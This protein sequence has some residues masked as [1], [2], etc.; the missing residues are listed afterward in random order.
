MGIGYAV[1]P[2]HRMIF[3]DQASIPES[4]DARFA[5]PIPRGFRAT[6]WSEIEKHLYSP[7]IP[8]IVAWRAKLSE[9]YRSQLLEPLIWDENSAFE[10]SEDVATH[11]DVLLRYV[12]ALLDRQGAAEAAQLLFSRDDVPG[13]DI[14]RECAIAA[15]R[16]FAGA[17]PQLLLDTAFWFPFERDFIIEEPDWGGRVERFGSAGHLVQ[18]LEEIRN[19]IRHAE[20]SATAWAPDRDDPPTVLGQVWQCSETIYRLAV[21]ATRRRLPLWTTG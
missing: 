5:F 4:A 12:A 11:A 17:Y 14:Q 13:E 19:F 15:G 10:T 1:S 6:P 21:A 8:D 9:K 3:I 7:T 20:P 16:G 18:E 2:L